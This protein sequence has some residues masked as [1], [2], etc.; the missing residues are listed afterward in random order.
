[1][2]KAT[3][4]P[5]SR[6]GAG[7]TMI[8][9]LAQPWASTETPGF[10]VKQ[11]FRDEKTGETTSLMK[12]DAGAFAPSHSHDQFEEIYVIEGDFYDA[13]H[14][15]GPGD[16]IARAIGAAHEAGS[17]KGGIVLLIYRG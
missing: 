15:Y 16:Y 11:L 14:S 4:A 8:E 6:I 13:E 10:Y 9:A 7:S 17:R 1:M 2:T 12:M 5:I 3:A